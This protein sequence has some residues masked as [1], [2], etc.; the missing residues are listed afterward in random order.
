MGFFVVQNLLH[1]LWLTPCLLFVCGF[2][3]LASEQPAD[4]TSVS[5]TSRVY[6]LREVLVT[7]SRI[8][9][10][11]SLSAAPITNLDL[12]TF[13]QSNASSLGGV[14]S[15]V[16]GLFVKDYG[17]GGSLQTI[18]QRGLGPEHTVVLL[19]GMRVGNPQHNIVDLAL[20]STDEIERIE[21]L[22]GGN[23]ASYGAD[24]VAGVVNV[25]TKGAV[26]SNSIRAATSIGSFGYRKI[27]LSAGLSSGL[28]M[29]TAG[30]RE[31]KGR[32]NFPFVFENG[33]DKVAL[34]RQN[35][36][37]SSR[38]GTL[39]SEIGFDSENSLALHARVF[40]SERGIPGA[41]SGPAISSVA[42]QIDND[43]LA[44]LRYAGSSSAAIRYHL[45]LQYH[46]AKYRYSDPQFL[47]GS[48]PL[49]NE[50]NVSEV[51][52][53]PGVNVALTDNLRAALGFEFA[54]A[55]AKGNSLS[56]EIRRTSQGAFCSVEQKIIPWTD[57]L[58]AFYVYPALRFDR[59][60][61][62]QHVLSSWSPQLGLVVPLK[63]L[64]AITPTLRASVSR[65]FSAPTFN[66]LYYAGG[67]GVGNPRLR[68]ERSS[69]FDVGGSL[70]CN[71]LGRQTATLSYFDI[72]M[73]DRIQWVATGTMIVTPKNI[74]SVRSRGIECSYR[75]IMPEG[76]GE[77]NANYTSSSTRKI[78]EDFA[79][80]PNVGTQLIY[81]PQEMANVSF[82]STKVFENEP[83]EKIGGA[84]SMMY[85]G[86]VF[87]TEDNA[88]FLPSH[89]IMNCS[90]FATLAFMPCRVSLRV[91]ANNVFD[92]SYQ[93][94]SLYPMPGRSFRATL[95]IELTE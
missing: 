3:L 21:I 47:V 74:R 57:A 51:R 10:T 31:E 28:M 36:D 54:R 82:S 44:Q 35:A 38:L 69:S 89:T 43:D 7:A 55:D 64:G 24:A 46:Y 60:A 86:Y 71:F 16:P 41:V 18:A 53:E 59:I 32:N 9:Q 29:T 78:A 42:R 8:P 58:P 61:T 70:D 72:D 6:E 17:G 94:I 67:G 56:N 66:M 40:S 87:T 95:G 27:D 92:E 20:I 77:L 83:V 4:S 26:K 22:H 80:D 50:S 14:L 30:Y 85:T 1:T 65:N 68:P 49:Y 5:D 13:E 79:G 33:Q 25:V 34:V 75:W 76:L 93:V 23:S 62:S 12:H 63:Q 91:E 39:S 90:V 37:F 52:V 45:G 48:L 73:N 15:M 84:I 88:S 19:N 2:N 11:A 81:V